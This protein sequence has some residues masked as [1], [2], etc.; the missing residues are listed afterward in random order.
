MP[1]MIRK[2]VLLFVG[3]F[4][5]QV[6]AS[7][8]TVKD[9]LNHKYKKQ[10]LALRFPFAQGDMKFDSAGQPLYARP[11]G[12][13]LVYGGI[14]IEDLSLSQ[15]ALQIE[16]RRIASTE[17]RKGKPEFF[18]SEKPVKLEI[19]LDQPLKSLHD[20]Q[21]VL[22]RVFLLDGDQQQA[23]MPEFRRADDSTS[24]GPIYHLG[25]D[26]T[27]VPK[28]TFTPEPDFSERA[29]KA[30][31]QG[32]V[33]LTIVVD[34]VGHVSRVSLVRSLGMGLDQAAMERVK[35]WRFEPATRNGQPVA[36]VMNI[37]VSFNLY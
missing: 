3:L 22:G 34:K 32:T 5:V 17:K 9:A 18:P 8:G 13:W 1:A 37:E 7:A 27:K 28:A 15:A 20:A 31:F 10:I 23:A 2:A 21:A 12:P 29:R 4:L 30:K 24:G 25:E 16:G 36:V 19:H 26:G 6:A 33:I 14:Y 11:E 35:Q